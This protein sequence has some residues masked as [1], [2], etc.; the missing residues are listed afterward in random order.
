MFDIEDGQNTGDGR[1]RYGLN[2]EQAAG[3]KGASL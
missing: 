1:K 3:R 2:V